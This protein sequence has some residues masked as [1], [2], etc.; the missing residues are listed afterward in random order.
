MSGILRTTALMLGGLL[1]TA[2]TALALCGTT[3]WQLTAGQTMN[4]GT[5]TVS[6]DSTNLYIRYALDNPDYPNATFGTLHAW[7]G[8][9]LTNVPANRNGIPVP[10]QF[11]SAAGGACLDASGLKEHTFVIPLADLGIVDTNAV[12]GLNLFVFTHA[13]VKVN[14]IDDPDHETAW[15]GNLVGSTTRWYF[16]GSYAL[17]CDPV[18]P[19]LCLNETAFAKGGFV[20]TTDKRSN[21]EKLPS[22]NLTKN[23]WGW[24]IKLTSTGLSTYDIYAG[25][26]L[27]KISN[28]V[29]VGTL[30]INWNGS[31]A[32]VTYTM[33]P[34]FVLNEVHL[35]AEDLA[36]TT[37]APGQFGLPAEGY[38][39]GGVPL[40]AIFGIPLIDSNGDGVWVIAHAVV[41]TTCE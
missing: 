30:S 6:N 17:C 9:D 4:V 38:D 16:Y 12:C 3:T 11:C 23:R 26:G 28:G 33:L 5:V 20:F 21:P 24:A 29:K 27:N 31:T 32:D 37:V 35:F 2:T 19:P 41:T 25:A 8:N 14:G 40:K 1:L 22:L 34:G 18:E 36:P 39:S 13:E 15:G 10:G 7:A